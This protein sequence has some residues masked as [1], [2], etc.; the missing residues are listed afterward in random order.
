MNRNIEYLFKSYSIY[1]HWFWSVS[2]NS[3]NKS[4]KD[5]YSLVS[6]GSML[7]YTLFYQIKREQIHTVI[8]HWVKVLLIT[9]FSEN[10]GLTF[11]DRSG[12]T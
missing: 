4:D 6:I 7:F 12:A 5:F 1:I 2:I 9:Y 10:N 8:L 3:F 11:T